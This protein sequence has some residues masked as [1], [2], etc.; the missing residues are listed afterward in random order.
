V[1]ETK[2]G[3]GMFRG[4]SAEDISKKVGYPGTT[5]LFADSAAT[6]PRVYYI[7]P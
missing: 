7:L 3:P 4:M 6:K 1:V 5:P 2:A